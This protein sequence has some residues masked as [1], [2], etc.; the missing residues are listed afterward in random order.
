[1][2]DIHWKE[3][4]AEIDCHRASIGQACNSKKSNEY[5]REAYALFEEMLNLIDTETG[6]CS[7]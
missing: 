7:T 1:M 4:L 2:L 3:H 5:K 6:S